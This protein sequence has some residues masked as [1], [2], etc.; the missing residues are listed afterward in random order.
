VSRVF[1]AALVLLASV[2]AVSARASTK[3]RTSWKAPEAASITLEEGDKV[4]AMVFSTQEESRAGIEALL[5]QEL[6]RR[7]IE[8]IPAYTVIPKSVVRD[9][10]R[11]KPYIDKTGALYAIV[12]RVVGQEKELRGSGPTYTAV[13]VYTGP[14]YGGFY[15]GYYTFGWGVAYTAGNLQVDEIVHVETLIYDLRTDKLVWAGMSDTM[16]PSTAQEVIKDLVK[17][18]GKEMKKQGLVRK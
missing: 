15:G 14:Y 16:N 7:G 18:A 10:D 4:L 9:K 17:A 12:M 11:A 8:A 2:P 6:G 13:P 5:A 1:V 3:F